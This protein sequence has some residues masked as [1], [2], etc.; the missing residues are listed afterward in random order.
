[1]KSYCI[2]QYDIMDCGVAC[3]ATIC[4]QNGYKIGITKT[5]EVTGTDK[6]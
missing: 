1:M 6:Q 2:K 3:L 4:K 5:R